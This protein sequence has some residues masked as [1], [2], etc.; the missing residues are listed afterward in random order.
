LDA[1]VTSTLVFEDD[2]QVRRHAGGYSD[3]L[4]RHRAL[5]VTDEP[6]PATATLSSRDTRE[7]PVQRK[8][9]YKLQRELDALPGEIEQL[10]RNVTELRAAVTG[11]TF[12]QRPHLDVQQSLDELRKA[13]Q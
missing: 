8:L 9:S 1:I 6:T 4:E 11:P 2:G 7:K 12:Y 5:A 13:E 3:W 10:E